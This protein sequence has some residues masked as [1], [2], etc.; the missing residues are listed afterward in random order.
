MWLLN[1]TSCTRFLAADIQNHSQIR[2]LYAYV[3]YNDLQQSIENLYT[4]KKILKSEHFIYFR[5]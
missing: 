2:M 5:K 1:D 3:K 4:M